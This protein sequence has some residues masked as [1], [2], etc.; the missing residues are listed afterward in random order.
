M[1]SE[2]FSVIPAP[3][4]YDVVSFLGFHTFKHYKLFDIE[5][6][7]E[8]G[9]VNFIVTKPKGILGTGTDYI[10]IRN[11]NVDRCLKY[12]VNM[13]GMRVLPVFAESED[14]G[15]HNRSILDLFIRDKL[16]EIDRLRSELIEAEK[17]MGIQHNFI[18]ENGL[19]HNFKERLINMLETLRVANIKITK[20]TTDQPAVQISTG[21]DKEK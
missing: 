2:A 6:T 4:N 3:Q 20:P 13:E 12:S 5:R 21:S 14:R 7:M 17:M 9:K 11:I 8:K 16:N 18:V 1:P 10:T 15:E 19:E